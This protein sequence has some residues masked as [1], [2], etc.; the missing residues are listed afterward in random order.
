MDTPA[1][2]TYLPI[3]LPIIYDKI[4]SFID[5]IG[6]ANNPYFPVE[7]ILYKTI[8]TSSFKLIVNPGIECFDNSVV[9][10]SDTFKLLC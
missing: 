9:T 4:S 2:M 6:R 7:Y 5:G 1:E 8:G 10:K 3:L